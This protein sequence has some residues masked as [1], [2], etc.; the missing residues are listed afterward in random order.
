VRARDASSSGIEL[1]EGVEVLGDA[2]V[3][4]AGA[5][6]P[7]LL[8]ELADRIQ[9]VGQPILYFQPDDV[10]PFRAPGF[11][12]WAADIAA[13]GWYGF[14]ANHEGLVK[15]A[16]HGPGVPMDPSAPRL[17]ALEWEQ[18]ARRFFEESLPA[19]SNARLVA[20]RLCLYCDSF[21]GDMWITAHPARQG[22]YVAAGGSGHGFKFAPLLGDLLSDC[23]EGRK[24]RWS[25]RFA[26]RPRGAKRFEG[27]RHGGE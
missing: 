24:H 22:V 10:A 4:A 19:L 18:R 21:D 14:C 1:D 8:P 2:V 12:P 5:W 15:V 3:I 26:W 9:A 20:T 7:V 27:A 13:S 6:T 17:V 25:A 11:V 16:N 23:V